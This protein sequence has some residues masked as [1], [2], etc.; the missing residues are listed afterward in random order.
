MGGVLG[1]CVCCVYVVAGLGDWAVCFLFGTEWG[2]GVA[3]ETLSW[4]KGGCDYA[5]RGSL[6]EMWPVSYTYIYV[7][8]YLP[9]VAELF[10]LGLMWGLLV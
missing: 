8:K 1:T 9:S 10:L 7:W 3:L 4:G 2:F 6:P 5:C